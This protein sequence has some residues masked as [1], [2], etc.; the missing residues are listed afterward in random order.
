[1]HSKLLAALL[2]AI[3]VCASLTGCKRSL[4]RADVQEFVDQADEAAR[5]RYAPEICELRAKSFQLHLTFHAADANEPSEMDITRGMFCREAARFSQLRQYLLER[6]SLEIRVAPDAKSATVRAEYVETMP[7]YAPGTMPRTPDDFWE[8]Q[9]VES[10]DESVI[11]IE[12]G[13]LVFLSTHVESS[14]SVVDKKEISL[15]YH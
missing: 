11:G 3:C 6:K 4:D 1:M 10:V 13:D 5:K 7:Y 9:I 14:Q 8:W 12:D 2:L 15:P